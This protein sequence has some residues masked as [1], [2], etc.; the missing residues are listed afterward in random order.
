MTW[1]TFYL[2]CFLVG[3][4]L[5]LLSFLAGSHLHLPRGLHV[6]VGHGG[7]KS[8]QGSPI[9]FATL[10]AFLTWFGGTGY[11]LTKY[12]GVWALLALFLAFVTGVGG[13]AA[14]FW[15]LIKFLLKHDYELDP[16]DYDMIGVLGRISSI[17]RESGTGEMIYSQ[18]GARRAA[19]V[20]SDTGEAIPKGV[21]VI[22]TRYEKGIAYVRLW[23]ELNQTN[24]A[25]STER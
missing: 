7:G 2:V 12:S 5:S 24:T 20:R 11:L 1:E 21:E 16:A 15:F 8:G 9:N 23:D 25:T 13:A 3:F 6:H 18:N 4:F 10:T 17:V 19:S 22:V 14:V